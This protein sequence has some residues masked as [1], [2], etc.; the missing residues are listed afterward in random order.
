MSKV[1]QRQKAP[2]RKWVDPKV[3]EMRAGSA[4][5]NPGS[6]SFDGSLEALGS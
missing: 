3:T 6:Q 2:K 4:E 5:F 1:Q